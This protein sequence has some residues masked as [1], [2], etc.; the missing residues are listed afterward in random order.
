MTGIRCHGLREF[1]VYLSSFE[2]NEEFI[3][4]AKARNLGI[5]LK[6]DRHTTERQPKNRN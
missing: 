3:L 6:C 4:K 1:L 2:G 5:A